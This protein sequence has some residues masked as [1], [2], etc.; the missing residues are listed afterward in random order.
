MI[1]QLF[2]IFILLQLQKGFVHVSQQ[3]AY[4][5]W[6]SNQPGSIHGRLEENCRH[7]NLNRESRKP[8]IQPALQLYFSLWRKFIHVR[9]LPNGWKQPPLTSS[10][11]N[12]LRNQMHSASTQASSNCGT[13]KGTPTSRSG[14]VMFAISN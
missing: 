14:S 2:F 10:W 9:G 1:N 5:M 12:Q 8:R 6:Q 7:Q 4:D 3:A 11:W 13:W